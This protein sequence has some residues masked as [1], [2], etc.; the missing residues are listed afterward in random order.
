[1]E[2]QKERHLVVAGAIER[3]VASCDDERMASFIQQGRIAGS[4]S[5]DSFGISRPLPMH[6]K[7]LEGAFRQR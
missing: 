3:R 2:V 7:A 5:A 6:D 4:P 1:M